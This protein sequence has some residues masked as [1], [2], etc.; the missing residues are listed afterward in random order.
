[1]GERTSAGIALHLVSGLAV[2]AAQGGH[3]V[4]HGVLGGLAEQGQQHGHAE[5]GRTFPLRSEAADRGK[6]GGILTAWTGEAMSTCTQTPGQSKPRWEPM[7]RPAQELWAFSR[8]ELAEV[9]L[10]AVDQGVRQI[11]AAAPGAHARRLPLLTVGH[12]RRVILPRGDP[13]ETQ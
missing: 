12:H 1:M 4:E 2:G 9:E 5:A 8:G 3:Q 11:P 7:K 10:G 13:L 6:A